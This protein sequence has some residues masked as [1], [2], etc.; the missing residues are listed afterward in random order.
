MTYQNRIGLGEN[1]QFQVLIAKGFLG[2]SMVFCRKIKA[3]LKVDWY[4]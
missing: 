2:E 4:K 1:K 3:I